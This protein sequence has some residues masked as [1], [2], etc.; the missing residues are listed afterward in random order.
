M[1]ATSTSTS[2]HAAETF[3]P[4]AVAIA[5]GKITAVGADSEVLEL[6]TDSTQII[7]ARGG[8]LIPGLIDSHIHPV[9]GLELTRG[10]DLGGLDFAGVRAALAAEAQRLTEGEWLR[11]WNLDYKVFENELRG[12]LFDDVLG[13]RPMVLLFY[14]LHTAVTNAAALSAAGVTGREEFADNSLVVTDDSGT[15]TGELREIPAY[16]LLLDAAPPLEHSDYVERVRA[17]L[18]ELS[19][20]G[21]TSGVVT[22]GRDWH[23]GILNAIESSGGLPVRLHLAMWHR[24]SDDDARV[25]E[26]ISMLGTSGDRYRIQLIKMFMD[27]V[28]DTGTAWLQEPDVCGQGGRAFWNSVERY[29]E[30]TRRYLDAGYQIA[31]HSCGDAGVAEILRTYRELGTTSLQGAPNRIEHLEVISD[32]DVVVLGQTGVVASMQPLHMQWR[33]G[34]HSDSWATRLGPER[35]KR[36]FRIKDVLDAGGRVA[37]GSDWPVAQHDARLGMA[38]TRL[39]RTPGVPEAPVFEPDQRLSGEEALLGYTRWAAE[40]LGRTDLGVITPGAT[41]DLAL[42]AEDPVAADPD[43]LPLIPVD[44]TMV[45]GEIVYRR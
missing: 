19:R 6:A 33:E 10:V 17:L 1:E 23:L 5:D 4:T 2:S 27:G 45:S 30:V 37:L 18:S 29:H 28:I 24:P 21:I 11:G 25:E 12:D 42:F 15:P 13:G 7:D 34:D 9:W 35:A 26:L 20:S 41:A 16:S 36:A 43:Q 14:D 31:T 39:R 38:W 44:W 3:E 22:D 8:T 32:D 40:A